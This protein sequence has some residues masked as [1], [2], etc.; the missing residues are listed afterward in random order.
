M[1]KTKDTMTEQTEYVAKAT[2]QAKY[3]LKKGGRLILRD[4]NF[5]IEDADLKKPEV[6]ELLKAYEART[7]KPVFGV[8]VIAE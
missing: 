8:F 1:A 2:K 3:R 6:I 5:P 4:L 7:G